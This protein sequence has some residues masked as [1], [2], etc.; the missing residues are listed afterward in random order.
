[1]ARSAARGRR[2]AARDAG[3]RAGRPRRARR[4]HGPGSFT[5][6]RIGLAVA[7]GLALA[8]DVPVA[9]V[10]TLDALAAGAPGRSRSI[11]A[12]RGEVFVPRAARGRSR[13]PRARAGTL[14]VGTAR[15]ATATT[16]EAHGRRRA[17]GR[18]PRH[19]PARA[20]A[21]CARRASFGPVER[22]EPD[23]RARARRRGGARV[24]VELRRLEIA[25]PRRRRDDRARVVSDAVVALDVR[26]AS[27][28]SRARSR[29]ARSTART[30]SS[31]TRSSR[32][33]ST[34]GT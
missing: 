28:G 21:R 25:R 8:L 29:S 10:S 13:R 23:L 2:R 12:R 9:G 26:R 11:D 15:C 32:A 33:T 30:S 16:L 17:A 34:P 1:M 20:A 6:T 19:R 5:S 24:N 22:V 14:C 31:A 3:R 18:R 27:C 4:R 7:R